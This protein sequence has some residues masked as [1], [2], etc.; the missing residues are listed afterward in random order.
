MKKRK[1][2]TNYVKNALV[3]ELRSASAE[4]LEKMDIR[5]FTGKIVEITQYYRKLGI[6]INEIENITVNYGFIN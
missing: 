5:E 4:F 2:S 6:P 3:F 1:Q